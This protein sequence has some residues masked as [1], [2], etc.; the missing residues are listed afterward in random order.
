MASAAKKPRHVLTV[1]TLI[2]HKKYDKLSSQE[3][4]SFCAFVVE[5]Y[6]ALADDSIN[7]LRWLGAEAATKGVNQEVFFQEGVKRM[8]AMLQKANARMLLDKSL[9]IRRRRRL[10]E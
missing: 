6:G 4:S 9:N 2:K 8:S 3:G 10:E 1:R 5:S 7:L